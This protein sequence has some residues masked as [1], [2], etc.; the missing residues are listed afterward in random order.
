[1]SSSDDGA[2][3]VARVPECFRIWFERIYNK[4]SR[5]EWKQSGSLGTKAAK[6]FHNARNGRMVKY[7]SD[8]QI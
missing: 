1:M 6:P 4:A 8:F 3:V 2:P 7:T 5:G